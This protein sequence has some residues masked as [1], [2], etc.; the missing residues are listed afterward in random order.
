MIVTGIMT[1]RSRV[2]HGHPMK[3]EH[4]IVDRILMTAL[5]QKVLILT[6]VVLT[7][8]WNVSASGEQDDFEKK[9]FEP[10]QLT[11]RAALGSVRHVVLSEQEKQI[12]LD[13]RMA[14]ARFLKSFSVEHD[15][16]IAFLTPALQKRFEKREQLYRA[17]GGDLEAHL[18]KVQVR[19]FVY[20]RPAH[21][22]TFYVDLTISAE[23]EDHTR[24]TG[25]SVERIAGEWKVSRFGN[26]VRPRELEETDRP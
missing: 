13:A 9:L 5:Q 1:P 7:A 25:F 4:V 15:N 22:I 8:M 12:V 20:K 18:D 16:P 6:I 23:G 3:G 14:L 11:P 17:L 2:H 24:P 26:D 19:H 10:V 21:E